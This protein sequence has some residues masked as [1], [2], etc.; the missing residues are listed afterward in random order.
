MK[1]AIGCLI[2]DSQ[3]KKVVVNQ[4]DVTLPLHATILRGHRVYR[5]SDLNLE[6]SELLESHPKSC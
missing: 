4:V 1:H 3:L 2:D 5:H 6:L